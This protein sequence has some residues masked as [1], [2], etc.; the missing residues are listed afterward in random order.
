[1][2]NCVSSIIAQFWF[3]GM[4]SMSL[5]NSV[6]VAIIWSLGQLDNDILYELVLACESD[7]YTHKDTEYN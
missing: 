5:E 6:F 1:M 7:Y 3:G 4:D 2:E